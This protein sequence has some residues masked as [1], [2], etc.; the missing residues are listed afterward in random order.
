[1]SNKTQSNR[2][3]QHTVDYRANRIIGQGRPK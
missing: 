1:M 2:K 3:A